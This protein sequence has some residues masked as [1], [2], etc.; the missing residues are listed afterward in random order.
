MKFSYNWITELVDGLD[1][2]PRDLERLITM[3]TAECEG[4]E[5]IG[6]LLTGASAARIVSVEPV[7]GGHNSKA[8]SAIIGAILHNSQVTLRRPGRKSKALMFRNWL[9]CAIRVYV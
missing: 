6:A 9:S 8:K 4:I 5:E 1:L 2:K 3:K 7:P